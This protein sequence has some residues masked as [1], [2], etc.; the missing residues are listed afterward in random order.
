[1]KKYGLQHSITGDGQFSFDS[2]FHIGW[3]VSDDLVLTLML[4]KDIFHTLQ[5]S[6]CFLIVKKYLAPIFVHIQFWSVLKFLKK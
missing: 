4:K 3:I 2:T 6:I 1:M 5:L